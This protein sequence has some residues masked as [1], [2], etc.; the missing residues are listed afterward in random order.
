[1]NSEKICLRTFLLTHHAAVG[2]QKDGFKERL[3][4]AELGGFGLYAR[5][6]HSP[7]FRVITIASKKDLFLLT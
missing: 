2:S 5:N 3:W 7:S 4:D 1:M 6:H